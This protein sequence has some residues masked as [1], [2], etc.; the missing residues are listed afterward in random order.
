MRRSIEAVQN[1]VTNESRLRL[2][3]HV[4][5]RTA[6]SKHETIF[7]FVFASAFVAACAARSAAFVGGFFLFGGGAFVRSIRTSTVTPIARPFWTAVLIV[8]FAL[9]GTRHEASTAFIGPRSWASVSCTRSSFTSTAS[10]VESAS[11]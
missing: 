2:G 1:S 6:C 8:T 3:G 5:E 10:G 4:A 7:A 9:R 11:S